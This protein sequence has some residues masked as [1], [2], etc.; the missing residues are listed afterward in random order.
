[1]AGNG[2]LFAIDAS[3]ELAMLS[4]SDEKA[5]AAWVAN[6]IE[7]RWD[8]AW[9]MAMESFWYPVH[10]CLHGSGEMPID[11]AA[12]EAK[13]VFGGRA[14]GVPSRYRIDYKDA[15]LVKLVANALGRMRDEAL[16][17]RAGLV[18]RKDYLGPRDDHLQVCVVD[19]IRAL[20]DFYRRAADAGRA[21]IFTVNA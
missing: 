1:M 16:W 11:G 14:L 13:A 20:T 17:A 21:V 12:A 18:E 7:E 10:F 5:R 8:T 3:D 6:T 2:V 4:F 15:A 19:E 9:L